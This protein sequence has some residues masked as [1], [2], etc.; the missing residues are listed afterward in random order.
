M[1]IENRRFANRFGPIAPALAMVLIAVQGSVCA[2][3]AQEVVQDA[4]AGVGDARSVQYQARGVGSAIQRGG[5]DGALDA[6]SG[7]LNI[8]S[9]RSVQKAAGAVSGGPAPAP[10]NPYAANPNTANSYPS[11]GGVVQGV[12]SGVQDA[13]SL[14]ANARGV[15]YAIQRGGIDGALDAASATMNILGNRSVQNAAVAITGN[16]ATS[17]LPQYA[18]QPAI[19]APPV[20]QAQPY[21]AQIASATY[22]Y[23]APA[24]SVQTASPPVLTAAGCDEI[25]AATPARQAPM[26]AVYAPSPAYYRPQYVAIA[27]PPPDP[28]YMRLQA[29]NRRAV[30][31]VD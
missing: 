15:G 2:Q 21:T 24:Q 26:T 8:F 30:G 19:P 13:R 14:G 25:A 29:L 11:A 17:P 5:I 10:A 28:E 18:P 3:D 9:N 12:Q 6:A 1:S 20:T 27:R 23:P 16:S 22:A 31:L 4:R 7:M